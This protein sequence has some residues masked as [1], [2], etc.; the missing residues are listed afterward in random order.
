MPW[1][2]VLRLAEDRIYAV[3]QYKIPSPS[4]DYWHNAIPGNWTMEFLGVPALQIP[5]KEVA[6]FDLG[7]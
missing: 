2:A 1:S 5:P 4:F 3:F 7:K 6:A